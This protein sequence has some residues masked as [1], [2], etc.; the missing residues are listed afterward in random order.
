MQTTQKLFR[1]KT[2]QHLFPDDLMLSAFNTT[3]PTQQQKNEYFFNCWMNWKENECR[4]NT[5]TSSSLFKSLTKQFCDG[6]G[7]K[8]FWDYQ[9]KGH[10][11]R[12]KEPTMKAFYLVAMQGQVTLLC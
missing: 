8:E 11:I 10:Q 6:M 3:T 7:L 12:F 4:C 9:L 5:Q 1:S 2:Y